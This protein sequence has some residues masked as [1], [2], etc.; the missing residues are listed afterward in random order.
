[1]T[2]WPSLDDLPDGLHPWFRRELAELRAERRR[3]PDSASTGASTPAPA[4]SRRRRTTST[5]PGARPTR[6]RP[7]RGR[8]VVI[9]GSGPNRIG[10][11]IEFDYCCVHAAQSLPRARLRG[12][13][14]QLQPGDRLDRLRHLRPALLRAARRRGGARRLRA[15]AAGRRRDPVRRPDAAQARAGARGGRLPRSSAPRTTPIDLAEDRERFGG[16]AATGSGSAAPTGASPVDPD[17]AVEVAERV[18][19]PVLVRPSY[20]L[21]GRAMRVCYRP[22]TSVRDGHG[23][24]SGPSLVDR[25]LEGA[26]EIDVDALC[27]GEDTYVGAVME[28]VEEAGVHSGDSSCVLPAPSLTAARSARSRQIVRTARPGA[29][30]RRAAERPARG[31][32]RRGLR[33]RGEPARVADGAVRQ[34]G[35][36]RQPRRRRLPRSPPARG[37]PTSTCR[38]GRA[39]GRGLASR[40]RCCRSPASPAPTRCSAPRC[41]RPAR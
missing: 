41:A 28:H 4:R 37:S 12:G 35:D 22:R 15:R 36:R 33:A 21:G 26:V 29:R 1:M 23:D 7:S 38:R 31:R 17:E 39:A 34:Q 10:Q 24:R 14:G 11:G 8:S 2:P 6:R 25:F 40:R 30:R 5:R 32:R 18:G 19:Y 16:S 27:D 3:R 13:D 20:V 9:L